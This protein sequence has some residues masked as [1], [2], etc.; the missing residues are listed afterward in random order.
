[1][2][3]N[4]LKYPWKGEGEVGVSGYFYNHKRGIHIID[5]FGL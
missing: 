2:V 1:V 5:I 4:V 3:W